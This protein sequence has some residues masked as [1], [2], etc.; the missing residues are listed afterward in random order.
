MTEI[1]VRETTKDDLQN[2]MELWNTG[3]VMEFVG[4]PN[5]LNVNYT[6]VEKWF[7]SLNGKSN[8]KHYSIYNALGE[9]C[10]ETYYSINETHKIAELDI[11]L[12]LKARG[13]GIA[14]TA[15]LNTLDVIFDNKNCDKAYVEPQIG[16]K[17]AW[18]LYEKIGFKSTERPDFLEP[19]EIYLE[20]T[21]EIFNEVKKELK[22]T[23]KVK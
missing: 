14:F 7:D 15:L 19:N 6:D 10:G 23:I 11:K 3:E 17:N 13:K 12:N 20:I 16:N 9:Y 4:F 5:G 21:S 22:R 2:L 18:K 8:S 1:L